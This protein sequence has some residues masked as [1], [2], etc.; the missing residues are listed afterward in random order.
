MNA[1]QSPWISPP[2]QILDAGALRQ[3]A[4]LPATPLDRTDQLSHQALV[5]HVQ[6]ALGRIYVPTGQHINLLT[7]LL[8]TITTHYLNHYRSQ[9]EFMGRVQSPNTIDPF[10]ARPPLLVTGLAG[11]GKTSTFQALLRILVPMSVYFPNSNLPCNT[12]PALY[13][14]LEPKSA[15]KFLLQDAVTQLGGPLAAVVVEFGRAIGRDIGRLNS[16]ASIPTLQRALRQLLYMRG[17]G[18]I[19]LDELQFLRRSEGSVGNAVSFLMGLQRLGPPV[20]YAANYSLVH[21]LH[22]RPQ[23]EKQRLLPDVFELLPDPESSDDWKEKVRQWHAVAP[24]IFFFE[25]GE[26]A[27]Q[28]WRWTGGIDRIACQL[29]VT[30]LRLAAHDKIPR[31]T[32]KVLLQAFHSD[33]FSCNRDDVEMLLKISVDPHYG[34]R[35]P[36]LWSPYQKSTPASEFRDSA[37]RRQVQMASEI[38]AVSS[39]PLADQR[40]YLDERKRTPKR[41]KVVSLVDGK[42]DR[43]ARLSANLAKILKE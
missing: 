37:M 25:P 23:E 43:N 6:D 11:C 26:I 20:V 19:A 41:A 2:C 10:V 12:V 40:A 24:D 30:G 15:Q 14:M 7:I 28:L 4:Y 18:L 31:V 16:G 29:L 17:T 3:L 27:A 9:N 38:A 36:D 1:P 42:A 8:G 39:L 13:F 21:D 35:R 5:L 33:S 32:P 22:R 34:P